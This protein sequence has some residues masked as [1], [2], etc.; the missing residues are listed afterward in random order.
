MNQQVQNEN[1]VTSDFYRKEARMFYF[2]IPFYF[3]VP[4][5]I[6]LF[7]QRLGAEFIWIAF[8]L[9]ALGWIVALM[10]R[11]PI[12]LLVQNLPK[13]SAI[14]I[15]GL[16]SGPLEEGVRL[17]LL[18]LTSTSFSWALSIG[19]GWAAIEVLYTIINGFIL[20][21]VFQKNDEKSLEL[22]KIL[23]SQGT[24]RFGPVWGL[25]E[26]LF[27]S[28]FHIGATLIIAHSPSLTIY[29]LLVHSTFNLGAVW[30]SKRS[31]LFAQLFIS[32]VGLLVLAVGL[33][34][35]NQF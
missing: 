7:S 25:S 2:S 16:S 22:K 32:I 13:K 23:E 33:M 24:S 14:F 17:V 15:V 34:L 28:L 4:L 12:S 11:G 21:K 1:E 5:L 26:R 6:W 27:A 19:Q 35:F 31:M 29:I 10:L 30:L 3:V 8:G 18:L 20:V 9:G